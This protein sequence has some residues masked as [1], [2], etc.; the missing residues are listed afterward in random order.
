MSRLGNEFPLPAGEGQG[1]GD[2]GS[3]L[4][5]TWRFAWRGAL[6]SSSQ[7]G[8]LHRQSA[9]ALVCG[10]FL[11]PHPSPL[12]AERENRTIHCRQSGVPRLVAARDAV[13][14]A[15]EREGGLGNPRT[16]SSIVFKAV[17][18]PHSFLAGRGRRG[19]AVCSPWLFR[20]FCGAPVI[21]PPR[22]VIRQ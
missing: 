2:G 16:L 17:P 14:P 8:R 5:A 15:G 22:G 18:S 10:A 21:A 11:P 19:S 13:F 20:P 3:Q 12:P 9:D 4:S 7:S 6:C 1:E